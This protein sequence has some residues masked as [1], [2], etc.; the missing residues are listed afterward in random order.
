[1]LLGQP[2]AFPNAISRRLISLRVAGLVRDLRKLVA[3]KMPPRTP[4]HK[5]LA[6][7][8]E[9]IAGGKFGPSARLPSGRELAEKWN[10]DFST[11]NRAIKHLVSRGTLRREGYKLFV[12]RNPEIAPNLPPVHLLCLNP[13]ILAGASEVASLYGSHVI[14]LDWHWRAYRAK[15]RQLLETGCEGLVVWTEKRTP[16]DDLLERFR[17]RQIPTVTTGEGNPK[18]NSAEM[19]AGAAGRVAVMHLIELGH[20]E[21]ACF[22]LPS[23][24]PRVAEGYQRACREAGLDRSAM[25]ISLPDLSIAEL[26]LAM[27]NLLLDHPQVTAIFFTDHGLAK[28]FIEETKPA[29]SVPRDLSVVVY[30]DADATAHFEPPLTTVANDYQRLGRYAAGIVLGQKVEILKTGILP[31]SERVLI[32]P[33]L[34]VRRSTAEPRRSKRQPAQRAGASAKPK[35]GDSLEK[36]KSRVQRILRASYP[37]VRNA[38]VKNFHPVDLRPYANR[39]LRRFK[40]WVGA[41][42]LLHLPTGRQTIH[43][44]PFEIIE[45]E[46]NDQRAAIVLHSR[47]AR[48]HSLPSEVEITV[49]DFAARIYFLHGCGWATDHVKSAEYRIVYDDGSSATVDLV[50]YGLGPS[51]N[52]LVAQWRQESNIQDWWP[53]YQQFEN[54]RARHLVVTEDSNPEAYEHYLYTLEWVNPSPEKK[55]TAIR[56]KSNPKSRFTLGV[57]AIS[58]FFEKPV[59]RPSRTKS[60]RK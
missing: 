23:S 10:F 58:L 25:R 9:H 16:I 22:S 15:V 53:S 43:G 33:Q 40:S 26:E 47:H 27:K 54:P 30:G 11:L 6:A 57:L 51:D 5:V 35:N 7:L 14:P 60:S 37:A 18:G 24:D 20:S 29:R 1:M 28:K 50:P 52:E 46:A 34:I 3:T 42:P 49:R 31:K 59:A 4:L 21:I 19:D 44:I 13:K 38:N 56:I 55:L 32:E 36:W 48:E 8:Q 17:A 2:L 41:S 12:A 45:E 39:G